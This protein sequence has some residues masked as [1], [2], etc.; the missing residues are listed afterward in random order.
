[1]NIEPIPD[2]VAQAH[3][4]AGPLVIALLVAVVWLCIEN[5]PETSK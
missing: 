3:A 5:W 4:A 2:F 1:M